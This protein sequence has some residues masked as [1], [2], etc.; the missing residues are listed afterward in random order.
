MPSCENYPY[1]SQ[2]LAFTILFVTKTLGIL[3]V[4]TMI[5]FALCYKKSSECFLSSKCGIHIYSFKLVII[6]SNQCLY[7][8]SYRT[9]YLLSF[10]KAHLKNAMPLIRRNKI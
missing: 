4:F 6:L 7:S 5:E 10:Q 8:P 1:L 3:I 2:R 9:E